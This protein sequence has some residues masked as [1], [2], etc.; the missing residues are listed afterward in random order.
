MMGMGNTSF[1]LSWVITYAVVYLFIILIVTTVMVKYVLNSVGFMVFF[2]LYLM[3]SITLIFQSIFISVFFS[4]A[5]TGNIIGCLFFIIQYFLRSFMGT[6]ASY[7][8]LAAVSFSPHTA[9]VLAINTMLSFQFNLTPVDF[10]NYDT[11]IADYSIKMAYDHMWFNMI[12]WML[13]SLY[14]D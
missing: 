6:D 14:L 7:S 5:K 9:F 12:F 4:K 11:V 13:L 1:Y 10:N 3:F 8:T 2:W